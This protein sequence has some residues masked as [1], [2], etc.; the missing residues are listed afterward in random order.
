V[1]RTTLVCITYEL[2]AWLLA[3]SDALSVLLV[4][5][6]HPKRIARVRGPR[7]SVVE[8][9]AHPMQNRSER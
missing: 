3:D 7:G 1:R 6:N 2:E 9:R 5:P 8:P 4:R